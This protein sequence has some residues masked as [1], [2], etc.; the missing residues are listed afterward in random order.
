MKL[1]TVQ[2]VLAQFNIQPVLVDVG[3]S[4]GT[5]DIWK[6]IARQ[7]IYVGFDPD[8]RDLRQLAD[9]DFHQAFLVNKALTSDPQADSV[10][11]YFTRS[12]YCSSTLLPDIPALSDF[13][14]TDLFTVVGEGSVEA[15]SL[16]RVLQ[17]L[18]LTGI[19]WFKTDSQGIDLRLFNSIPDDVRARVLAVDIEPGLIHAYQGEDLFVDAH[20]DLTRQG[21]WL[22]WLDVRGAPRISQSTVTEMITRRGLTPAMIRNGVRKTPGWCEAR[23]LRSL[24][25]MQTH[26]MGQR[27]YVLLWGFALVQDQPGFALDVALAYQK[28]FGSDALA[29]TLL[30]TP[31]ALIR[32]RFVSLAITRLLP[33]RLKNSLRFRLQRLRRRLSARRGQHRGA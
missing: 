9:S 7:A 11:F 13:V 3:A 29:R 25:W 20:K 6:D 16:D 22:S 19:D 4:A 17:M 15:T 10:H 2:R 5:P 28:L 18:D 33:R 24:Q 26:E 8:A 14:Y 27:E 1:S 32:R 30:D 21:F 12:P 31:L 23:Y